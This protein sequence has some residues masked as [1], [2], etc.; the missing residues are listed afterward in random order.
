MLSS[1]LDAPST[2][3]TEGVM[4]RSEMYGGKR[5]IFF[6]LPHPARIEDSLIT[7]AAGSQRRTTAS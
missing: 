4:S 7:D 5:S 6:D 2:T 3:V 1:P